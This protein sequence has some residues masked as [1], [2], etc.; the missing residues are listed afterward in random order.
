LNIGFN[1]PSPLH[2]ISDPRLEKAGVTLFLKRDDLIH[3]VISGNKWRK[4]KYNIIRAKED[5]HSTILSFGGAYSNHIHALAAA[6]RYFNLQTIGIIRGEEHLPLNP[7]LAYAKAQGMSIHY[8][9]RDTYRKKE[10]PD[11]LETLFQKFGRVYV[12]PEGGCNEMALEGCAEIMSETTKDFDY[13]CCACGTGA[14]LAGLSTNAGK[15]S[16]LGFCVLKGDG[17]LDD[18]IFSLLR[19]TEFSAPWT[20]NYQYH[21]GGYGKCTAQLTGFMLDFERD[22]GILLEPLYTGKMMFGIFDLLHHGYFKKGAR[23]M[24]IHTGGLQGRGILTQYS[25]ASI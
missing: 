16:V 14:T 12:L 10:D 17:M 11:Y 5:Q 8:L 1:I 25:K 23:I 4:L 24:A 21:F 2:Q 15:A 3:P 22:T 18:K 20:V 9:D 6:G 7:T 19:N 13:V